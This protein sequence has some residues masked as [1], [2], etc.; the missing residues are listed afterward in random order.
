MYNVF[1]SLEIDAD[2]KAS[3][4]VARAGTSGIPSSQIP[5]QQNPPLFSGG[6]EENKS[7]V[8][9]KSWQQA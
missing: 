3:G 6:S 2:L 9:P 1:V 8:I 5:Q 4:N 7:Y